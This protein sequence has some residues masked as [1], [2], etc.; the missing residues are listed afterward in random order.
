MANIFIYLIDLPDG[1]NEMVASGVDS[2]T[3][4]IDRNLSD[5]KKLEA[6]NHALRHIEMGHFDID[7]DKCVDQIEIEAHCG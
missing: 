6:Y 7:C 3:V 5:E 2:F 1:I 4:Y